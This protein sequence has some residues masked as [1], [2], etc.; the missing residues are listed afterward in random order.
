[1]ADPTT[2]PLDP[3]LLQ[4]ARQLPKVLLHEHLDGG[5][6]VATL[7]ALLRERG[8]GGHQGTQGGVAGLRGLLLEETLPV[9]FQN[10]G[11]GGGEVVQNNH[12]FSQSSSSVSGG[13]GEVRK[14]AP[15]VVRTRGKSVREGFPGTP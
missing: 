12:Q 9:P 5:L 2:P 1:M 7:L 13:V 15:G 6:R 11:D 8:I 3:A 14:H 4:R 10:D